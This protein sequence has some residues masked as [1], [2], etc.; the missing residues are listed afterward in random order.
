MVQRIPTCKHCF[1]PDCLRKW[2]TSKT[3]ED[4]QRCPQCNQVL[5]SFE[6]KAAKEKNEL[7]N[8]VSPATRGMGMD[9][10]TIAPSDGGADFYGSNQN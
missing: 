1:H 5:K 3:Q 10:N 7:D 8:Y 6:M 2:F 4:E 9:N